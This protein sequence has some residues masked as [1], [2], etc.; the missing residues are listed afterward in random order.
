LAYILVLRVVA[1]MFILCLLGA[2]AI[3]F[4][5]N[6]TDIAKTTNAALLHLCEVF[7]GAFVGL[8]SGKAL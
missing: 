5:G 6:P 1:A 7:G 3:A 2:V 8:L 4:I